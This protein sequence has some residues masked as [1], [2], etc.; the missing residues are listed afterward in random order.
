MSQF[1]SFKQ[2]VADWMGEISQLN[3][4]SNQIIQKNYRMDD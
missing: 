3:N 2:T 1:Q 4:K